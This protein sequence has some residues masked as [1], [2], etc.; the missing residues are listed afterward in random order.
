[1]QIL[2]TTYVNWVDAEETKAQEKIIR[3]LKSTVFTGTELAPKKT[4]YRVKICV[5]HR[6]K[7]SGRHRPK[8]TPK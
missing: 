8:N 1:L 2:C 7:W 6:V 4:I 5:N 3:S